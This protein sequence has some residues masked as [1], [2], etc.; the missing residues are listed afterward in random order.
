[1]A[2]KTEK[3]A[4]LAHFAQSLLNFLFFHLQCHQYCFSSMFSEYFLAVHKNIPDHTRISREK[5]RKKLFLHFLSQFYM[6]NYKKP[7]SVP[8]ARS[9]VPEW[10]KSTLTIIALL[11]CSTFWMDNWSL[12]W[13]PSHGTIPWHHVRHETKTNPS[14]PLYYLPKLVQTNDGTNFRLALQLSQE[15]CS[16]CLRRWVFRCVLTSL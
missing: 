3:R 13:V 10:N 4:F 12:D 5:P 1:M 11:P 6:N 15:T 2:R 14:G 8:G 16:S 7:H 9:K